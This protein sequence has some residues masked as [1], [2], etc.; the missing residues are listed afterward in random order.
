MSDIGFLYN[1]SINTNP[2]RRLSPSIMNR[3]A[4]VD[5]SL[6]EA[7]HRLFFYSPKNLSP[8][9]ESLLGYRFE[10]GKF[11]PRTSGVPRVNGNW[12]YQ[13]RKLLDRGMGYQAFVEWSEEQ[14]IGV[15]VPLAFSE[16]A[17]NKLATYEMVRGYSDSLYPLCERYRRSTS[18]LDYFLDRS[19][20]AYLKPRGGNKGD[21]II[22]ICRTDDGYSV[23]LYRNRRQAHY[24]AGN[25][26]AASTRIRRLLSGKSRYVIQQGIESLRYANRVFD[27]RVVM[28]NDAS[29]W[30][31]LHEI[32][33]SAPGKEL[34]NVSQGG[35]SVST[36]EVLIDL[37]GE[38]F[39]ARLLDDIRNESYGLVAHLERLHPGEIME[40]AF[41]FV[42]DKEAR[43]KLVEINTKPGLISIGFEK[44]LADMERD[45]EPALERDVLP[46]TQS[47][48]RFLLAKYAEL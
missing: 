2:A 38:E 40:V 9:T 29:R 22:T 43:P 11:V 21:G 8:D 15:F 7:G 32:R 25:L 24:H 14:D 33:L 13:T 45:D 18:Q 47:V 41:D 39:A 3:V 30:H 6:R 23:T 34:S 20:R 1:C 16:L 36:Q 5:R 42:V 44:H 35:R 27:I 28:F 46:H 37:H 26:E 19:A 17:G 48:A 12:T 31:W 4:L 10:N